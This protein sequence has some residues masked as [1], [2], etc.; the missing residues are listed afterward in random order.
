MMKNLTLSIETMTWNRESH[1]LFDYEKTALKVINTY[2]TKIPTK[3]IQTADGCEFTNDIS[4]QSD[5]VLLDISTS[6]KEFIIESPSQEK[7][8]LIV[9]NM[10]SEDF[11]GYK[12]SEGD[13]MRVGRVVLR[14]KEIHTKFSNISAKENGAIEKFSFGNICRFCLND[15][16]SDTNLLIA[17]CRCTGSM[18]WIHYKC[19]QTWLK[20]KIRIKQGRSVACYS[21]KQLHCEICQEVYPLTF[22][23]GGKIHELIDIP[24]P[25]EPYI[26]LQDLRG[27]RVLYCKIY[28]I[29]MSKG[30]AIRIGRGHE[31][32]I[33]INDI[34]VSR[35][36]SVLRFYGNSVYL[37]DYNSK[38]GTLV[39]AQDKLVI[40][41]NT[42]VAVQLNRR[43][44]QFTTREPFNILD[45]CIGCCKRKGKVTP[46]I[47]NV[48]EKPSF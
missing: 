34:S 23:V 18:K 3:V 4:Y 20:S 35:C 24:R 46:S 14:V 2:K 1:G 32:D 15:N 21:W 31:N 47:L 48:D 43:V 9:K 8:W 36:H 17:P 12:L 22:K 37:Q 39:K 26:I 42:S 30:H 29:S 5:N 6:E 38:F 45:M 10:T 19:L 7:F 28:I 27:Q 13:Y 40:E 41:K 33:K 16:Y 11:D 25:S 44:M